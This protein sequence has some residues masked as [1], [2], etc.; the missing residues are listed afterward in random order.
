MTTKVRR[1]LSQPRSFLTALL[2]ALA[3]VTPATTRAQYFGRN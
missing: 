1:P 2:L 3:V